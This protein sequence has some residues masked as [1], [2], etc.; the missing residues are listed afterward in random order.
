[1]RFILSAFL[2]AL[3]CGCALPPDKAKARLQKIESCCQSISKLDFQRVAS[4]QSI[5]YVLSNA[6]VFEFSQGK[7]HFVALEKPESSRF[8]EITSWVNGAFIT[9]ADLI[10]PLI[11]LLDS[12]KQLIRTLRPLEDWRRGLSITPHPVRGPFYRFRLSLPENTYYIVVHADPAK[13][14]ESTPYT[15]RAP[16]GSVMDVNIGFNMIG[17]LTISFN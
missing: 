6:A 10:Y 17:N 7:S 1:M 13:L 4:T 12:D 15:H 5:E 8:I 3:L 9:H 11:T 14:T 2:L 16:N